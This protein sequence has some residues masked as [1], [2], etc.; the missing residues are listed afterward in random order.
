MKNLKKLFLSLLLLELLFSFAP[1]HAQ[2]PAYS[3]VSSQIDTYLCSPTSNT[4]GNLT[5]C[6]NR[7]YKFAIIVASVMGVFFI[8]IAGYVYMSAE[9]NSESVEKAKSI[10]TST[11]ASLVILFAGYILLK[12][13]NPDLIQFPTIQPPS[14]TLQVPTVPAAPTAPTAPNGSVGAVAPNIAQQLLNLNGKSITISSSGSCPGNNPLV[15]IQAIANGNRAQFDGPGTI[16]NAGTTGID[17]SILSTLVTIANSGLPI[18]ITSLTSG[19]H[20]SVSDPHY[21]GEAVDIVP[22]NLQS[23]EQS[24]LQAL[25]NGGASKVAVECNLNGVAQFLLIYP[26]SGTVN[27]SQCTGQ[28][29]YHWHAQWSGSTGN[30]DTEND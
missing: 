29:N 16:C 25:A 12:A 20:S 23:N 30:L 10:L 19:H 11:I 6:I 8:V 7:L 3:G 14:V 26:A 28:P 17:P 4:A 27:T 2:T 13:I 18:T 1:A 9:G 21:S 5:T 15:D 22:Q 24:I